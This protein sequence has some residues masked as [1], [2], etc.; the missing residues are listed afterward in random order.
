MVS[1]LIASDFGKLTLF[2]S[3]SAKIG[4]RRYSRYSLFAAGCIPR[5][6]EYLCSI[7]A[8]GGALE[9]VEGIFEE[10]K[11]RLSMPEVVKFYGFNPNFAGMMCCPFHEDRNPSMKIYE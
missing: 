4:L 9:K 5:L 1:V 7:N 11:D 8:L 2:G 3:E 6:F 10:I